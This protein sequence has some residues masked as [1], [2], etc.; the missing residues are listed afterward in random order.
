MWRSLAFNRFS[1]TFGTIAILVLC[2]NVYIAFN[3]EGRLTGR[4]IDVEGRPVAGAEVLISELSLISRRIIDATHTDAA[5]GFS[6]ARHDHHAMVLIAQKEGVGE[7]RRHNI[8]L[9]FRNQNLALDAPV[10]I[11]PGILSGPKVSR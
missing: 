9:Y 1:L 3:D 8:R 6:F 10:V 5:G 4:V 7:S 11:D 2:W